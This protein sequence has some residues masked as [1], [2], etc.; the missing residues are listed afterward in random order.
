MDIYTVKDKEHVVYDMVDL[1]ADIEYKSN[2]REGNVGDWVLTDDNRVI[3][4]L[5]KTDMKDCASLGTCT[6]T[7]L[8]YD[9]S[10]MDTVKKKHI[11]SVSGKNWYDRITTRDKMT[12]NEIVFAEKVAYGEDP[13]VAYMK[14]YNSSEARAKRMSGILIRQERIKR[15]MNKNKLELI[16]KLGGTEERVVQKLIDTAFDE[17][18]NDTVTWNALVKLLHCHGYGDNQKVTQIA[19]IFQGH[20]AAQLESARRPEL[21]EN[22]D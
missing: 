18:K 7:Y 1:P 9:N 15:A 4:I 13:K 10:T 22:N 12:A 5:R 11:Y 6:G 19:G 3:Q 16:E 2:W 17:E 20:T 21:K 14:A 8:N